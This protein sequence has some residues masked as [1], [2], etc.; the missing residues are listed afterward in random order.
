MA[1]KPDK[2]NRLKARL[3]TGGNDLRWRGDRCNHPAALIAGADL[4]SAR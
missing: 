3:E 1:E 2:S 4:I